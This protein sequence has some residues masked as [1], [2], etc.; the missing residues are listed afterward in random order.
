LHVP[1]PTRPTRLSPPPFKAEALQATTSLSKKES[2]YQAG[3][4]LWASSEMERWKAAECSHL[5]RSFIFTRALSPMAARWAACSGPRYC[6]RRVDV[7][8]TR[9]VPRG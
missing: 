7:S 9:V 1:V 3:Y 2:R 5:N 4:P 6:L 8:C